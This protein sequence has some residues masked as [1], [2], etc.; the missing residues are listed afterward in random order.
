MSLTAF[1]S[2]ASGFVGSHLARQLHEQGWKVHVLARSTSSLADIEGVP[3]VV[4]TGDLGDCVKET[5]ILIGKLTR[6]FK[7]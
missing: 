7:G 6:S 5:H 2:G 3:A 1:V 4:H